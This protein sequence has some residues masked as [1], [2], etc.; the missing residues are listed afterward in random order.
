MQP[1]LKRLDL[2][3]YVEPQCY[4]SSRSAVTGRIDALYEKTA[5]S[6]KDKLSKTAITMDSW[7]SLTTL[8]CHY[9]A[10]WEIHSSVLKTRSFVQRHTA[11]NLAN[12]LKDATEQW[13]SSSE[14]VFACVHDNACNMVLV[15]C[16]AQTL[17]LPI[18]EGFSVAS[19]K[20]VIAAGWWHIFTTARC[21]RSQYYKTCR[22]KDT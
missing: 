4:I 11:V 7:T 6:M 1:E 19:V 9:I 16:F 2:M 14:K 13:L 15:P 10:E 17:Q 20:S 3:H 5:S 12:Y 22:C 21:V 18:N 8:T